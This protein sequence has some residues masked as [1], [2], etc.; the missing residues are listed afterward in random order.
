MFGS[1]TSRFLGTLWLVLCIIG[2]LAAT[3]LIPLTGWL[4]EVGSSASKQLVKQYNTI[5]HIIFLIGLTAGCTS[6]IWAAHRSDESDTQLSPQTSPLRRLINGIKQHPIV[7]GLFAFYTALM[8]RQTSWFYKE[9]IGWYKDILDGHLLNNFT[10][11]LELAKE[12][13]FRNDFRFFPLSHQDLH[14]LSWFTPYV[15]IWMLVNAA[16]LFLIVILGSKIIEILSKQEGRSG[17]L[18]MLSILFLFDDA[19]GFTFFQFIYSERLVVLFFALYAF[20][21]SN[22]FR[23]ERP[24]DAY[25]ASLYA[26][27]GLFFKDTA[28]ILFTIP[29][30]T[31]I[32]AGGMGYIKNKPTFNRKSLKRWAK[33]YT[34]ELSLCGLLLVFGVSFLYL[35]Y[36]PSLYVGVE[37]YD[38]Y[39]RFSR[40]EPD[41]RFAV[42][43]GVSCI[44]VV[45]ITAKKIS[46]SLLDAFNAA[47]LAYALGLFAM[48]GFR[49][50]NYMALP[51]QFMA[52][53]NLVM[54]WIWGTAYSFNR[55]T[56]VGLVGV[57]SVLTASSLIGI[58]HLDRQ[59]FWSRTSK[60]QSN[61]ESWVKTLDQMKQISI[62]AR[63]N[64][65]EINIIY[66]KSLFRNRDH[67]KRH[68]AYNRLIYFDLDKDTYLVIDGANKGL[69]YN[70]QKGDFLLNIDTG[71]RLHDQVMDSSKY[72]KI[73]D[74]DP[75]ISNGKI[76][77]RLE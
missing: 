58:E 66:S 67:L 40:F 38:S 77:R 69:D 51:V 56:H 62:K 50:S 73:Y 55:R 17:A 32:T 39:L 25:L 2:L 13:M 41:L 37:A 42:L 1:P 54:L 46:F 24:K 31:V 33:A 36:L 76:Y 57:T 68:L 22:H 59:N 43:L 44:R 65:D 35:S 47:A 26:L 19:T 3:V 53:L 20:H 61:Q 16:E 8:M 12:T 10:L 30:I 15:K 34:L 6:L 75:K 60:I 52:S 21:H 11:R 74:Y 5:S 70:P 71:N 18:L 72:Q 27:L 28:F 48:V 63:E 9:I 45:M 29:A 14:I 4:P 7:T 64:G 23:S 49:S